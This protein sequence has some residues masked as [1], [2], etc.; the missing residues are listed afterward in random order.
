MADDQA[1]HGR[2]NNRL[3]LVSQLARHFLCQRQGDASRTLGVHQQA[4]ALKIISAVAAGR[5]QEMSFE[6]CVDATEFR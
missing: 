6:Q 2:G 1:T 5:Q 4:C 3:D